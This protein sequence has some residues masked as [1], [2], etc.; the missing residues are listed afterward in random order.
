MNDRQRLDQLRALLARLERLPTSTE[1]EWMLSEARA[2]AV[3]VET[4]VRPRPMRPLN[5]D[6]APDMLATAEPRLP[7]S[8]PSRATTRRRA[9]IGPPPWRAM[10]PVDCRSGSGSDGRVDL[11][12]GGG[13][14]CLEDPPADAGCARRPWAG[15]L[16]G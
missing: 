4:G 10:P 1:Q 15:G 14:L 16:R 3:D 7:A 11:L 13:L 8:R 9:P 6:K 12:E 2:R 5:A